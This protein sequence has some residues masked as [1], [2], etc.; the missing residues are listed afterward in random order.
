PEKFSEWILQET[1]N[2]STTNAWKTV[3]NILEKAF[4]MDDDALN[5]GRILK[6][7][8]D[9]YGQ[10]YNYA[11][12]NS[13][14]KRAIALFESIEEAPE[15]K[16]AS[17]GWVYQQNPEQERFNQIVAELGACYIE[18]AEALLDNDALVEAV[19]QYKAASEW[20]AKHNL[21]FDEYKYA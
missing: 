4:S 8:A 15:V 17:T 3:P 6:K 2:I 19:M 21:P 12:Q 10:V 7:L 16:T 9:C 5:Q 1:A 20:A 14:L 18:R 11:K 13:Y